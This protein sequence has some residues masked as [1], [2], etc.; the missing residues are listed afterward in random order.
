MRMRDSPCHGG[1]S[2]A[3]ARARAAAGR[4]ADLP[5]T[6]QVCTMSHRPVRVTAQAPGN[7][8]FHRYARTF[9]GRCAVIH[10]AGGVLFTF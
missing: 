4:V 9:S 2:A 8:R 1:R 5:E 3:C 6:S 10:A 7:A